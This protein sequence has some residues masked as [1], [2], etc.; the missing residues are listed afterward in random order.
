M[1]ASARVPRPPGPKNPLITGHLKAFRANPVLFL[2]GLA[3]SYGDVC[4]FRLGPQSTYLVNN[5]AYIRDILVT[6]QNNFVKS[7]ALQRVKILLGEG[8][9]TS[10]GDFHLRQRRLAQPAFQR[11]RLA[12]YARTMTEFALQTRGRWRDGGEIDM[13]NE[14]MRLTLAIVAKTLF[15]A[16]VELEAAAIGE[17]LTVILHMFN[18]LI[19]P[20][21]RALRWLPTRKGRDFRAALK[22][23]D[24]VIYQLIA[25]RRRSGEDTGDLLS[26]LL[27]AREEDGS[28][29]MDDRQVRDEAMT[30]FLAGHETTANALTW[31][32]YLLSQNPDCERRFHQ[33]IDSVL[34]GRPPGFD[35]LPR[36]TYTEMVFAESMR[37]YPPAWGVGRLALEDYELG[38]WHIP[39][40]SVLLMSTWVT[41]RDPRFWPDP[42]R[43]DPERWTP[44]AR[45]SRPKFSYYPFG[46]G[47]RLC[48]G[49]RFAWMEGSLVLASIAQKW[50]PRL[51]PGH[52][53]EPQPLITLRPRYGMKMILEERR[54]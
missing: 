35:D 2:E 4:Y 26:M 8:L 31:T 48:I 23:L 11:Q 14:M 51:A 54:A 22:K 46:G 13:S 7:R 34:D 10:E 52:R 44:E 6:H 25:E 16:D 21:A 27:L 17:A 12:A 49:E 9:L 18:I 3:R 36:L 15:S 45:D 43:F 42:E 32:W 33:E 53:V 28:G 1:A 19:L 40:G 29:Q 50:R 47:A 24:G 30:L 39:A 41:H 5:P 37:L 38:D 20:G